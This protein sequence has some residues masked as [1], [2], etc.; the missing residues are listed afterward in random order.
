MGQPLQASLVQ[1]DTYLLLRQR[2]IE[3]NPV[4]AAR[5]DELAHY[6]WSSY[7]ASALGQCDPLLAPHPLYTALAAD[8]ASRQAGYR[9]LF[10]HLLDT[11]ARGDIR[12]ALSQSQPLGNARFL[13]TI[14]GV[15]GHRCEVKSR[16]RPRVERTKGEGP[17]GQVQIEL[18]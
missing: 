2:Y 11:K 8:E 10:R 18:K 5:V 13:D 17:D 7:H 1:E 3:L 4:R 15:T 9:A 14:E 6:R 16:G 12:L